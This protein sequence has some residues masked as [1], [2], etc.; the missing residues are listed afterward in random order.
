MSY[1]ETFSKNKKEDIIVSHFLIYILY[2]QHFLRMSIFNTRFSIMCMES[3]YFECETIKILNKVM[4]KLSNQMRKSSR[5]IV[6]E[7]QSLVIV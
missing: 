6:G 2:P 7:N 1:V 3:V 4:I 5:F